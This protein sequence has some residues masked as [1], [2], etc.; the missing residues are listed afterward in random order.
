MLPMVF[1]LA[2]Y[3]ENHHEMLGGAMAQQIIHG[4]VTS[5]LAAI[6]S[7]SYPRVI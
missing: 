2:S 5:V 4:K 7:P 3:L 6:V 1:L